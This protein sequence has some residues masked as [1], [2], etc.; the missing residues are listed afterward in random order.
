V[1]SFDIYPLSSHSS[2]KWNKDFIALSKREHGAEID[3]VI[4]SGRQATISPYRPATDWTQWDVVMTRF[5]LLAYSTYN[6]GD[7]IQSIAAQQFLPHTDLLIDR[8]NWTTDT[9]PDGEHK[10]ILNGWFTRNPNKWPPPA[11]LSPC[12]VSMHITRERFRPAA[13][14]PPAEV[15]L[16]GKNLEYLRRYQPIGARDLWT[17]SLL[18]QHGVESY[19]SGCLTLTLGAADG[20]DRRDYICAVDLPD[21]LYQALAERSRSPIF[22]LA[23]R[24]THGGTFAQRCANVTELLNLYAHA[25]CVITTRLHCA[26]PC[27]AFE[28]PI[29]FVNQVPDPYR[30]SGLLDLMRHCSAQSFLNAA[31]DFDF[32]QPAANSGAHLPLR[33]TLIARVEAFTA[34]PMRRHYPTPPAQIATYPRIRENF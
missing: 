22:R 2:A 23:H 11:F 13:L 1:S 32:N 24:D 8:D 25:K 12:L 26:L 29:L 31:V 21:E 18:Q 27:L 19:F 28:T 4:G 15:L 17:A 5:A 16:Q 14:I 3:I 7:E 6:L 9:V 33:K 10:I 34:R 30:L 20:R